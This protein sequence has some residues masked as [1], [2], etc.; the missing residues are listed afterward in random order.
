[1]RGEPRPVQ[2]GALKAPQDE[3]LLLQ[4][5]NRGEPPGDSCSEPGRRGAVLLVGAGADDV[6]QRAQRQPAARQS[7]VER[8]DAK[9]RHPMAQCV[10]PL[11]PT[12][13]VLQ[14]DKTSRR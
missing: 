3:T 12:D 14:I 4:R 6:V 7:P 2:I 13:A 5:I 1:M 9:R 8:R 11:D 10:R